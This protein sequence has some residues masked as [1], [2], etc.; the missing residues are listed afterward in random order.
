MRQVIQVHA[1]NF[2]CETTDGFRAIPLPSP[3]LLWGAASF[4]EW[5]TE[6]EEFFLPS[7]AGLR[8]IGDLYK[9][10]HKTGEGSDPQLVQWNLGTDALGT[11]INLAS[12]F[13]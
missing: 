11:M 4:D 8:T 10:M 2:R 1:A 3:K 7:R 12:V 9:R 5:E 6:L 13:D